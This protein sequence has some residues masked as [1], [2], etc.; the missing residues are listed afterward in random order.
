MVVNIASNLRFLRKIVT[1]AYCSL[2]CC[3]MSTTSVYYKGHSTGPYKKGNSVPQ[4][5]AETSLAWQWLP[6]AGGD[7]AWTA[8]TGSGPILMCGDDIFAASHCGGA[9]C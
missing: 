9:G 2:A 7:G 3:Y 5:G 1:L 8:R 4:W 6:A